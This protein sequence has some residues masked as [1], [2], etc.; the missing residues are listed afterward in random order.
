MTPQVT[1]GAGMGIGILSSVL[2]G[3][4]SYESGQQQK[5]ADDYNADVTMQ[6]TRNQMVA[7]TEKFTTLVGRQAS[8][9]AAS[10][11]DLASG[12][13]LL[14]MIATAARGGQQGEQILQSGTEESILQRYYGK[15]AAF[16]GTMGGIGDFL[17]GVSQAATGY[18]GAT[19]YNPIPTVPPVGSSSG[20]SQ[21]DS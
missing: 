20:S 16:S 2:S 10:G 7:S 14:I 5:Q 13:P 17:K 11:V 12:S 1:A 18:K 19:G 15:I 4:G 3:L 6:N 9:Y 8:G 21:G